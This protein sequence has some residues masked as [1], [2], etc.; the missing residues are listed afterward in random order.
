MK[1]KI[2]IILAVAISLQVIAICFTHRNYPHHYLTEHYAR[3]MDTWFDMFKKLG[4]GIYPIIDY[5]K[6]YPSGAVALYLLLSAFYNS[7]NQFIIFHGLFMLVVYL[8]SFIYLL[9]LTHKI[10]AILIYCFS[11]TIFILNHVRFD[12]VPV[13]LVLAG[14]Y[15]YKKGYLYLPSILLGIAASIKWFPMFMIIAM[16]IE[17]IIHYKNPRQAI[18]IFFISFMAY[19]VIDMPFI[20][21]NLIKYGNIQNWLSTYTARVWQAP[22]SDTLISLL[23]I[24]HEIELPNIYPTLI[25]LGLLLLVTILPH[26]RN[27]MPRYVLYCLAFLLFNKIYSPQFH[28]WFLPLLLIY[29]AQTSRSGF[30]FIIVILLEILNIA[31][32]PFSFSLIIRD[33]GN[34]SLGTLFP[35]P[36]F[37][38]FTVSI[39]L[40]AII[41]LYL[42][43][44]IYK[45]SISPTPFW[46]PLY[47]KYY[48]AIN[49]FVIISAVSLMGIYII[50]QQRY[51]RIGNR[52][53]P[54]FTSI[55]KNS[56]VSTSSTLYPYLKTRFR[57]KVFSPKGENDYILLPTT[58]GI[59]DRWKPYYKKLL[60]DILADK[61][62]GLRD[63][64]PGYILLEKGFSAIKN[65]DIA[66]E[67]FGIFQAEKLPKEVGEDSI[68][69]S[70]RI[71]REGTPPGHLTYGPYIPSL[72][73][74][75]IVVFRMKTK[76]NTID[77]T[78]AEIDVVGQT[79][80]KV[81]A[82]KEIHCKDFREPNV[83]Q[84]FKL[85][86][87][88][89]EYDRLE[90]RIYST[91]TAE[92]SVDWIKID[93]TSLT[94]ENMVKI[95]ED[96]PHK[97]Y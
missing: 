33:L 23:R 35:I 24:F 61:R 45:T 64:M 58:D 81:Y 18:K 25:T 22:Y 12:I 37:N 84:E 51:Y 85:E 14:F 96:F 47:R 69:P 90:F 32:Y 34:F 72:P 97:Y 55:E 66:K 36:S 71:A 91:G 53:K 65:Q 52:L 13:T 46:L 83:Y 80:Q 43:I 11:P 63:S 95:L 19:A 78:I 86:F 48:L 70:C 30:G 6:E 10:W 75:Y 87:L 57:A 42:I 50:N 31:I 88:L 21:L 93:S 44:Y 4:K 3:D 2:P 29:I 76:D 60:I 94:L 27:A 79:G 41:L 77:K 92:L 15:Y 38:I 62:Y 54:L 67:I 7:K 16:G 8:I 5:E 82:I 9:K 68:P 73:G 17:Q 56:I 20:T 26:P 74:K 28:F 1:S 59:P 39:I 49:C 40:R 89:K